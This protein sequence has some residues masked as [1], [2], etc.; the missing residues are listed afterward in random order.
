MV[1]RFDVRGPTLKGIKHQSL[2]QIPFSFYLTTQAVCENIII[3]E[4]KL[5]ALVS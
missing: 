3:N 4:Q 2:I 5:K 1:S